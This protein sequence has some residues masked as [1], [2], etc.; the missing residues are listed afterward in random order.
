LT[1]AQGD[2]GRALQQAE[3]AQAIAER[4]GHRIWAVQ[5]HY[6][7]GRVWL[8]LLDARRAAAELSYALVLAR[9]S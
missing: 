5:S 4:I 7:L 1:A 3:A 8:E 6:K 2:F 9:L